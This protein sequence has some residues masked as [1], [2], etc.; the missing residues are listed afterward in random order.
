MGKFPQSYSQYVNQVR[1]F[2]SSIQGVHV[3]WPSYPISRNLQQENR[4]VDKYLLSDIPSYSLIS[5]N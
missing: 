1:A 4:D 2:E 5:E 3:L